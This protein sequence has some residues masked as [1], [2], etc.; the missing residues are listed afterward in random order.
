MV[1]EAFSIELKRVITAEKAR[2][3]AIRRELKD[4]REFICADEKC[5]V[6]LT[7][8]NWENT[9]PRKTHF[10]LSNHSNPHIAGCKRSGEFEEKQRSK[11]ENRLAKETVE[12]NGII[13][14]KK[15]SDQKKTSQNFDQQNIGMVG[16]GKTQSISI[17]LSTSTK[18][19][20]EGSYLT[21]IIGAVDLYRDDEFDNDKK[22][23]KLSST[24]TLSLNQFFVNVGN[25][26]NIIPYNQ[27]RI[28][29][30]KVKLKTFGK[31]NTGIVITFCDSKKTPDL[32][33]NKKAMLSR[34][35]GKHAKS[36]VDTNKE[37][38]IFFR[39]YLNK[40]DNKW[41]PYNDEFYKDLYFSLTDL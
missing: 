2:S 24:E 30:G 41:K 16:L 38:F 9:N 21:S 5:Q 8:T 11:F 35:Y 15:I 26:K 22:V 4:K 6:K 19:S 23:L 32:Y 36:H 20:N 37:L 34:Y 33:T 13:I 39:G 17:N 29:Y 7:G 14:L 25:N 10:R 40:D 28:Y 27:L 31:D 3:M 1:Q 18:K 12:K